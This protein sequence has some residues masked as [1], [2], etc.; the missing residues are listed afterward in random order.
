MTWS[1]NPSCRF[2]ARAKWV[3]ERNVRTLSLTGAKGKRLAIGHVLSS[4]GFLT[5]NNQRYEWNE[6]KRNPKFLTNSKTT[7]EMVFG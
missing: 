7:A 4:D 2:C 5:H 1:H 3:K 6:V